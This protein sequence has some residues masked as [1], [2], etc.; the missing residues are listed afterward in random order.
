MQ[1]RRMSFFAKNFLFT[2]INIALIAVILIGSSYFIQRN[3]L[4]SQLHDSIETVTGSWNK[5]IVPSDVEA[6]V[7]EK[8]Y[9]GAVQAKIRELMD[10]VSKFNPNI[11]Q[12]Y[13]FG[14][15]LQDGNKTSVVAMPSHI[16]EVFKKD[17]LLVGTMYE[18]PAEIARTVQKMLDSGK[19]ELSNFYK[20]DYGTWVTIV[21]P[22]KDSSGK[23]FAYFGVDTDASMVDKGMNSLIINSILILAVFMILTLIAQY[24]IA[25]KTLSPIKDLIRGIDQVSEGHLD[26]EIKTGTDDLGVINDKFNLMVKKMNDTMLKVQET[27]YQVADSAKALYTNSDRSSKSAE[28]INGNIKEIAGSIKIQEQSSYETSRSITEMAAV[29]QMIATNSADVSD[30]AYAVEKK[31][32]QGDEVVQTMADQMALITET[33]KSTSTAVNS[34][35]KRSQEIGSIL[36]MI[37]GIANQTNLL[38]LNAAIE[39]ARVGEHGKGFAVVAGEVR[40]LAEQSQTSAN[41]ISVLI[42]EIQNEIRSAAVAMDQGTQVVE[43][44]MQVAEATGQLFSEI[45]NATKRVSS[46]IQEV[47]AAAQEISA[48]TDQISATAGELTSSVSKT[49]ANAGQ[50][51]QSVD[52]QKG[53]M[54]SIVEASN[55]LSSMSEELKELLEQFHV[56]KN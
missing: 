42:K 7:K 49:A 45:R 22:I 44:G 8:S 10:Q 9:E 37:T 33:V 29:I 17:N 12:A 36:E 50:I 15:E 47:S 34:L 6:A 31:S 20:D 14:T 1:R 11:A 32:I 28:S 40:K 43:K 41:Q 46:Q 16:M 48:G 5:Q 4:V 30:E 38:A 25:R 35:E 54:E 56:K 18:Q 21:Y 3:V 23:V 26:V 52:D 27:S 53:Y 24:L 2:S 39:A 55:T 19:P 13:I 51:A